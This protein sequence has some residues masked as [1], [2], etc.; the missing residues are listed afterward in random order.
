MQYVQIAKVTFHCSIGS[1]IWT[2]SALDDLTLWHKIPK[3]KCKQTLKTA[4]SKNLVSSA[5]AHLTLVVKAKKNKC[6]QTSIT[7]KSRI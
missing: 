1:R 2:S 3:N 4:N 5:L 6:K 7:I